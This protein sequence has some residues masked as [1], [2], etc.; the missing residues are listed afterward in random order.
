VHHI[1]Y[2]SQA[3]TPFA[4]ADLQNLLVEAR[5]HNALLGITGVLLYGNEQFMQVLEG[6]A[7]AVRKLYDIIKRDARHHNV[8]AYADKA[9]EQRAFEGWAMGFHEATS[10]QVAQ[11]LGYLAPGNWALDTTRLG[12][13]DTQLVELLRSFVSPVPGQE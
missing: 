1:I 2:L 8:S 4:D 10:S 7:S 11:V 6:E 12:Q 5:T 3:T 13:A 9:I